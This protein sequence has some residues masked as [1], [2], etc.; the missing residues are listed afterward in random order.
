MA[1]CEV[2]LKYYDKAK[3]HYKE[4]LAFGYD[5]DISSNL[6]NI[7]NKHSSRRDFPASKTKE[8]NNK[9]RPQG[10]NSTKN[11]KKNSNGSRNNQGSKS[12]TATSN[13][14]NQ[15]RDSSSSSTNG[16]FSHPLGYKAYDTI[17]KGYVD[18]KK[19]W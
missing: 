2:Q 16:T 18:E 12:A 4:A 11:Q 8:Q 13:R 15:K 19:P 1:N 7:I 10:K 14:K 3:L 17:N 6:Y 9:N 5:K